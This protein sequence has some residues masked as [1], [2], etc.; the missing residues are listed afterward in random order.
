MGMIQQSLELNFDEYPREV[1]EFQMAVRA[2][3]REEVLPR[4]LEL[5][6]E[7]HDHFAWDLVQKGHE[8][9]LTRAMLPPEF[10][11]LG[12]GVVGVCVAMEELAAAC[13]GVALIFGATM[14]GQAPVLLSGDPELQARFLPLFSQ[15]QAV[16]A[17]NAVC[18]EHHGVDLVVTD[19]VRHAHEMTT[20]RRDG[21]EY[22]INGHKR[23]ITNAAVANFA[24]V[25]VRMEGLAPETGLTCVMV[26]LDS[27][28]VTRGPVADKMG[29]RAC[30]G[31]ELF[32]E[33]VRVPASNLIGGEGEGVDI[34]AA[35]GNMARSSV[36]AV[37]VGVARH[38]LEVAVDFCGTRV[39]GGVALRE[40]QMTARKLAEMTSKVDAARLLYLAAANKVDNRLPAPEYEP[41]VAKFFADR[42]ATEVASEAVSLLG[43]RGYIREFG[44]EKILRDSYGARIYEGTA[45]ALALAI[46]DCLYRDDDEEGWDDDDDL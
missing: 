37:S 9:G 38:A 28:G 40:H 45:E 46:T 15:E 19:N 8:L 24:S 31:S 12:A 25:F 36:A 7:A 34:L 44:L 10:G 13:P 4:A 26:P 27:R 5:D 41:A 14:L 30:L 32:F 11:G 29:Y 1:A 22:V 21:D 17:C 33:D 42:M 43:S 20:M 2:F 35:Q 23:V 3:A 39:Q 16:L 6:Q 18:E